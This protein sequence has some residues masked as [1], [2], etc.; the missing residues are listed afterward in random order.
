MSDTFCFTPRLSP[1]RSMYECIVPALQISQGSS[2]DSELLPVEVPRGAVL[3][4]WGK[5]WI[6]TED[7]LSVR[8]QVRYRE[9][10]KGYDGWVSLRNHLRQVQMRFKSGVPF[11]VPAAVSPIVNGKTFNFFDSVP[12]DNT[13]EVCSNGEGK[14]M[15]T[16]QLKEH[17][18]ARLSLDVEGMEKRYGCLVY[19]KTRPGM[20]CVLGEA[21]AAIACRSDVLS[22]LM[23]GVIPV[24]VG[25]SVPSPAFVRNASRSN[26]ETQSAKGDLDDFDIPADVNAPLA[27]EANSFG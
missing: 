2:L 13:G 7:C 20:V 22:Q 16:V 25:T 18:I 15:L 14:I 5:P 27:A 6:S 3:E 24:A 19:S 9:N 4:V 21:T 8:V 23:G 10:S 26:T 12:V 11:V 17:D 1:T